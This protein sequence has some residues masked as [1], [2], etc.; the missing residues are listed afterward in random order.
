MTTKKHKKEKDIG[1]LRVLGS[2]PLLYGLW[3]QNKLPTE[4]K[5]TRSNWHV[6]VEK[7][8][9]NSMAGASKKQK[10]SK[11]NAKK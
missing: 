11:D 8:T 2:T 1:K 5:K 6:V 4:K 9:E 7:H 3:I 10:I